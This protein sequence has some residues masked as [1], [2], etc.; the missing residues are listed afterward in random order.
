[1]VAYAAIQFARIGFGVY[2]L[3]S[4]QSQSE[5]YTQDMYSIGVDYYC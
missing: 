5:G 4:K 2:S 3:R 1:M